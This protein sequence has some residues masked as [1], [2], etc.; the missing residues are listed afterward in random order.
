MFPKCRLLCAGGLRIGKHDSSRHRIINVDHIAQLSE[1]SGAER[2]GWIRDR[3]GY[4]NHFN[5]GANRCWKRAR[6]C[7]QCAGGT[8]PVEL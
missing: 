3:V 7:A 2:V 6:W 1:A 8:N 5:N 4:D